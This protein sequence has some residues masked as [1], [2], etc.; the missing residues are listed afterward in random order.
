M[1]DVVSAVEIVIDKDFPV[2]VDVIILVA[3]Y[4][5]CSIRGE[6]RA[7]LPPRNR[8]RSGSWSRF[9]KRIVPGVYFHGN[10]AVVFAFEVLHAIELGHTLE[11]AVEAVVPAVIGTVEDRG[12]ATGL[13]HDRGGVVAA[14][15][16]ERASTPS[17]P[18]TATSGSPAT[19]ALTNCPAWPLDRRGP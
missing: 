4:A 1:R 10:E 18:R 13:G 17:L 19:V 2:A 12:M 9:T 6:R 3:K 5:A 7:L 14:H 15:V 11:G 8:Q 16:I